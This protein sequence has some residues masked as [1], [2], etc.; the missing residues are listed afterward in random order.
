MLLRKIKK[1]ELI[2]IPPTVE[3]PTLNL[4]SFELLVV[5]LKIKYG[6]AYVKLKA[7]VSVPPVKGR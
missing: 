5:S 4:I 6:V 3:P 2:L 7:P 1:A